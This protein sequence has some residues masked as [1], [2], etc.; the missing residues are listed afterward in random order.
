M[1]HLMRQKLGR[2]M[3][4]CKT[5]GGRKTY[6]RTRSPN[7]FWTPSR[8]FGLLCRG[9]LY[10]K[11]RAL[12]PEGG[13]KTYGTRGGSKTPFLGGVSFVRFSYPLFFHPPVA[14]SEEVVVSIFALS[15]LRGALETE[16]FCVILKPPTF[17]FLHLLG[18][19]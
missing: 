19:Y 14:S 2:D 1:V 16:N 18:F 6:Q 15:L 5:Y 7:N 11:N 4:G 9:F 3:G 13:W 10:R 12:T 8:G 17:S